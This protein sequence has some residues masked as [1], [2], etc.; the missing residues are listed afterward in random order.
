VRRLAA[1]E[2]RQAAAGRL[3]A[4]APDDVDHPDDALAP[5]G[6]GG[7]AGAGDRLDDVPNASAA[8]PAPS[9]LTE[10]LNMPPGGFMGRPPFRRH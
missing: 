4:G 6:R 9:P 1:D 7:R 10:N 3:L 5:C 8:R 2:E